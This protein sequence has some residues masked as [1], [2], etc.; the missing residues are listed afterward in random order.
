[1]NERPNVG[2]LEAVASVG[3]WVLPATATGEVD[4]LETFGIIDVADTFS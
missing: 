4:Q 2:S 1:M 3:N